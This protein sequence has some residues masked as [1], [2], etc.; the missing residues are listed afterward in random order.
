[1]E[2]KY[3][4]KKKRG[5]AA[6]LNVLSMFLAIFF[7]VGAKANPVDMA[8]VRE[9]GTRF[10]KANT[11]LKVDN[12]SDLRLV[13]TYRSDDGVELFHVF[14]TH[15]GFVIVAA[16]DCARPILGYSDEGPFDLDNLPVQ[17]QGYLQGFVEQIQYGVENHLVADE[18]IAREWELVK[19]TGRLMEE[20]GTTAV[21]PL[22]TDSWNQNCYYNSK[23]P[24]DSNGPCG[25][26]Y[27]GC[28]ATSCSQIMRYWGY[29]ITGTGSHTYN[30]SGY[31]QQTAN[32]GATTY[33]WGNMPNSLNGA[34]PSAQVD[35]V[36]TLMW[37]CGVAVNMMYSYDGSGAY[38]EDVGPA[39][40]NYFGYSNDMT[41]IY[42]SNYSDQAWLAL[43]KGSLD[44]GRPVHYSGSDTNGAGGHA[45]VCDG[46]D[47]NDYLHFNWGW[48]GSGNNYF[49]LGALNVSI[50]QFN[51]DNY[52]IINIHPNCVSGTSYQVT[53]SASPSYGGTVTGSGNYGC[54]SGCTLTATPANGY[55]FCSWTE[56]GELV[57]T[58]STYSFIVMGDRNLV[59]NF[60]QN[61][62]DI[63]P[64]VFNLYDSYG[65]GWNGNA[66]TVSHSTG[67]NI[68]EELTFT[69]G[70]SAVFVRNVPNGA[71]VVL[72]WI[73][74]SWTHECSFTVSYENGATIYEGSG[75]NSNFAYEFD[76]N[77]NDTPATYYMISASANPSDGG[78][79]S[80]GGSYAQG[81]NCTLTATP[82]SGYV[83]SNW[84]KN[85]QQV[86]ANA[87]YTFTVTENASYVAN[88]TASTPP[89][90][91]LE[92]VAKYYPDATDP[93]SPYVKV[94]WGEP[95]PHE[96]D[97]Y[98]FEDGLPA[99]WTII[100]A[101]GDGYTWAATS[102]IPSTWSYYENLTLDWYHSGSNAM[103]SGSYINGVGALEPDDYLIMPQ[104]VLGPGSQLD[105]W[106]A[107]TDPNYAADH[108]G[109]FISTTGTNP[110]DFHSV[111]EWTL[112]AKSGPKAGKAPTSREGKGLR[113]GNWYNY[114]VDLSAYTG[115]AYIAFR[116]FNSYDMYIMCL[117]DVTLT[118]D[119]K[120]V[121]SPY[122]LYRANC[123]G[124]DA[125]L[126]AENLT[127]N[128]YIDNDWSSL[129]HDDYKYGIYVVGSGSSDI[130]W[131][132]CIE[133]PVTDVCNLVFELYDSYGDGW[134]GNQLVVDYGNGF[135]EQL[136]LEEGS[137]GN[138]T[139]MAPE[140]YTINLSWI[141]GSYTNEC[142]FSI[143]Y[144]SGILIYEST[145]I[146]ANFSYSF[147]VSC[148]GSYNTYD[149]TATATP[150][151]GGTV[152]GTGTYY[153]DQR[154]TLTATAEEGY[155]FMHWQKDGEIVSTVTPYT[156][157]VTG[158]D[159][160]V[161]VFEA[162]EGVY[163][164]DGTTGTN[165]YFPSNS[166]YNY[167]MTQQIYTAEDIGEGGTIATL[168]FF[169]G[170]YEKTRS[171]DIYM[172]HIEKT[173]F[174]SNTDWIPM[175]EA[176]LVFSGEVTMTR[177]YWTTITLDTPFEYNGTSNVVLVV[178][179]NSGNW[180]S[181]STSMAGRV[182]STENVQAIR[183]YS[184]D[185][186]YDPFNPEEY[187]GNL[188][189]MKNQVILHT[190]P[191]P[192]M[193][194]WDVDVNEYANTMTSI[195][196]IQI[197]GI[198]QFTTDLELGAFNGDECRGRERPIYVSDFGHYYVFLTIYG[199][200][201]DEITFRLYDHATGLES[202]KGCGTV[203]T[204]MSNADYGTLEEP[205]VFN[206]VEGDSQIS[207]F[208]QGWNWWST[209]VEQSDI[210]GL[211]MLQ[212]SLGTNGLTI[213]SQ[214]KFVNYNASTNKWN[215]SLKSIENES[216]YMVSTSIA[217][218]VSLDG[219]IASPAAHPITINP[220]WSWI[221]YPVTETMSVDNA[222]SNITPVVGDQVKSQGSFAT[223]NGTKWNGSLKNLNPGMGY[224]YKSN[225]TSAITFVYPSGGSK[226]DLEANVT[227]DNNHWVPNLF[228]YPANMT[229]MAVVELDGE[230]LAEGSA[231]YELAA[232]A[233]GECRGSVRLM[234]VD[235]RYIAFLTIAGEEA[236]E[237]HFGLYDAQTGEE[238][239]TSDE[240]IAFESN[241]TFGELDA[242]FVVHFRGNTGLDEAFNALHVYPN[243]VNR[244]EILH[245]GMAKD[246]AMTVEIVNALG[247]VVKTV[248]APSVQTVKAPSIPGI[249]TLR[250]SMEGKGTQVKKLVVK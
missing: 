242:P 83:F 50:Y 196:V 108:F 205:F 193:Y 237:L 234:E 146:N 139:R 130:I 89:A 127:G 187:G 248:Y 63:C 93:Y 47:N 42:K 55:M 122:N 136:T 177:G 176:N 229:M 225:S 231:Q 141:K 96:S 184:D 161:A 219:P 3:L 29:P 210:D 90:P 189:L 200:G 98:D 74:G 247:M 157:I 106:V 126:I 180:S 192:N 149:I 109:V 61:S 213:K 240:T 102:T 222:M 131:S 68:Y 232:F 34:T 53:A 73:M 13:A 77:C 87:S 159:H 35:A 164:G 37:H 56:D 57:S 72:G 181:N 84:T 197:E 182:F 178:D 143:F 220:G 6:S 58:E 114:T 155:L 46:Y 142:S 45:F 59:A 1:M 138:F 150:A 24:E 52:A 41:G 104:A 135:T 14:N 249:Y 113:M 151:N 195:G 118:T 243:P 194:H 206:F 224:M 190:V 228:A 95:T 76:V 11:K 31:P 69:S 111:Q 51:N 21:Q 4:Q 186:N 12:T 80:G 30:P 199:D 212:N 183:I 144:E 22:L 140:G 27:A 162:I 94:S 198:E 33:N 175:T 25:H 227:A 211:T 203:F 204:F 246:A 105:F 43:I 137:A 238:Y 28:V 44:L 5:F 100:D 65:D 92:V 17:M 75:L 221:G 158:N 62:G 48:G 226:G 78:S 15:K 125:T 112:S 71:H 169:N 173:S 163:I 148:N 156:F 166:Y 67:C 241:A 23:C 167:S 168:S 245:I 2:I 123:D 209:F 115:Q 99:G 236:A 207:S 179:D 215:G 88:F 214:S 202:T 244:G 19:T 160:Y 250:I 81:T 174:E 66:L 233:N 121:R 217:C 218:M 239:F 216:F 201:A 116:H 40:V 235:G 165:T 91:T 145:G 185:T 20:R 36:A 152:E 16:D 153:E 119:A 103:C 154:C 171:Y 18:I 172:A 49:A 223:Y 85:G 97:Y 8:T 134:N 110:S 38:S 86:S 191:E 9:V 82:H 132:N 133:K 230:E 124:S 120:S 54:G 188:Y 208:G 117:D 101:N 7:V 107:A 10:L 147:E 79:V 128:E 26:V 39:L 64:L 60:Y 129:D 170:G 32:F 70:S